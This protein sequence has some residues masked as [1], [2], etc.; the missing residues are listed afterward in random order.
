MFAAVLVID[1]ADLL[2]IKQIW[3]E[4]HGWTYNPLDFQTPTFYQYIHYPIMTGFL[5]VFWATQ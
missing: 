3:A 1:M 2:G 4:L 5:I